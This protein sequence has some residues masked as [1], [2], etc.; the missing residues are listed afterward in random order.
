MNSRY[1]TV[2]SNASK[3]M[4]PD[5]KANNFKVHL[6]KPMDFQ[7]IWAGAITEL[8]YT[9]VFKDHI[10]INKLSESGVK[11]LE[12]KRRGSRHKK[13]DGIDQDDLKIDL[14]IKDLEQYARSYL[15]TRNVIGYDM[16]SI[17]SQIEQGELVDGIIEAIAADDRVMRKRHQ[18]ESQDVY[19]LDKTIVFKGARVY[20]TELLVEYAVKTLQKN[21]VSKVDRLDIRH[22]LSDE[23]VDDVI[24]DMINVD[25]VNRGKPKLATSYLFLPQPPPL[26]PRTQIVKRKRTRPND[27]PTPNIKDIPFTGDVA[28]IGELV[29]PQPKKKKIGKIDGHPIS[30]QPQGD[31]VPSHENQSNV[32]AEDGGIQPAVS[33][34]SGLAALAASG[35]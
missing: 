27:I 29:T 8:L 28:P 2:Q 12:A 20:P 21:R 9:P 13:R 1:L 32:Q 26:R 34:P 30:T 24:D 33:P 4:Y 35:F 3:K 6:N 10:D 14:T 18:I 31:I 23:L 7:G 22:R 25:R 17:R 16:E 5:N 15:E 19:T 11:A